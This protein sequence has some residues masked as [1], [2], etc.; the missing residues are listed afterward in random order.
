[1]NRRLLLL[2]ILALVLVAGAG[3]TYAQGGGNYPRGV[4]EDDVYP[5]ANQ[6]YC[7][8]CQGVPLSECPSTQCRVWREEIA[9]YISEGKSEDEIIT[10]FAQRYGDKISGVPINEE[11]RQF[12]YLVPLIVVAGL[13]V[14]IVFVTLR[15]RDNKQHQMALMAAAEAGTLEGYDRPVPDNVDPDYLERFLKLLEENA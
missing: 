13:A 10:I 3:S 8:V 14:A 9:Q 7:D 1:M 11:D 6:M 4:T 2:L 15:W 12:T 5:V